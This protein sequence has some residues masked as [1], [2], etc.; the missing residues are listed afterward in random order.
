MSLSSVD[1]VW[2]LMRNGEFYSPR[3]LANSSG[4]TMEAA[5][6]VL[7]FLARYGFAERVTSREQIFRKI[8]GSPAPGDAFKILR[9]IVKDDG[10]FEAGRVLNT[11]GTRRYPRPL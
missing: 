11:S 7:E 9:M 6:R 2:S 4:Q 1:L 5:G 3:D 10:P 8:E